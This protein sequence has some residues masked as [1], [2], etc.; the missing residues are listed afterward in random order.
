LKKKPEAANKR[1]SH[2]DPVPSIRPDATEAEDIK[3][4][5]VSRPGK[6]SPEK[7][8]LEDLPSEWA[9]ED[10]GIGGRK[11]DMGESEEDT[12]EL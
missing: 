5:R 6:D 11:P 7:D 8:P 4:A 10:R 12:S 2:E 9:Q 3:N 1:P